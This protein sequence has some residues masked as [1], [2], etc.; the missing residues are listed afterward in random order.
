VVQSATPVE[1]LVPTPKR[2]AKAP[3]NELTAADIAF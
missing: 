3:G 2:G 1:P